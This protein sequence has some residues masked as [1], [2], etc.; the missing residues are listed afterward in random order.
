LGL[1]NLRFVDYLDVGFE[2]LP[3]RRIIL[4]DLLFSFT[5]V[6]LF[7]PRMLE[8]LWVD[9][10]NHAEVLV[11]RKSCI[12]GDTDLWVLGNAFWAMAML[13]GF[14]Y[15]LPD[16]LYGFALLMGLR[17]FLLVYSVRNEYST[18]FR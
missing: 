7:F 16:V 1:I 3:G 6:S 13:F 8:I 10:G 18:S 12:L 5:L 17:K 4:T 11:P 15:L 2:F 14:N 9:L